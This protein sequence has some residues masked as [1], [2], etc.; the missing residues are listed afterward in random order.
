MAAEEARAVFR[1]DRADPKEN[2]LQ[3]LGAGFLY[4]CVFACSRMR[5]ISRA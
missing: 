4:A 3:T 1:K 2:P 5:A